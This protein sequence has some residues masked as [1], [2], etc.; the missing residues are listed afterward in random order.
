VLRSF[1]NRLLIPMCPGYY[2]RLH[3]E[4]Y[5]YFV[6]RVAN[7]VIRVFCRR[8][9]NNYVE[10]LLSVLGCIRICSVFVV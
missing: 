1:V 6:H 2:L 9:H 7:M 10:F 8:Q 4:M 3:I 5:L